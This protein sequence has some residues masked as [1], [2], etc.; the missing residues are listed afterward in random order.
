M[1]LLSWLTFLLELLN[2]TLTVLLFWIY[3]FLVMLVFVLQW[4]SLHWKILIM[5]LSVVVSFH[6]LS[7]KLKT[8]Y[9]VSVNSVWL[10]LCC[11]CNDLGEKNGASAAARDFC[12]WLHVGLDVYISLI[13]N[14]RSSHNHLYGF[15]LLALMLYLEEITFFIWTRTINLNLHESS[16]RLVIVAKEF[17]KLPN[18]HMLIK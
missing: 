2:V 13:V 4:L 16:D 9:P 18:W 8:G 12:E 15:E 11:F 7:V 14:I 5:L 17:L 10:F 1:T 6:W 3:F